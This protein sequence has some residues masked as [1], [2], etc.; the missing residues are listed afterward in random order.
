MHF[1][2]VPFFCW[3][4]CSFFLHICCQCVLQI[5]DEAEN[6]RNLTWTGN[7]LSSRVFFFEV[8]SFHDSKTLS[9]FSF[10]LYS[11]NENTLCWHPVRPSVRSCLIDQHP[12]NRFSDFLQIWNTRF[13][14]K[15]VEVGRVLLKSDQWQSCFTIL[16]QWVYTPRICWLI[17]IKFGVE[18]CTFSGCEFSESRC[19]ESCAVWKSAN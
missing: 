14:Q 16:R 2:F 9:V 1:A 8:L 17:W 18:D 3:F 12:L 5:F 6:L 4:A 10:P 13:L 15:V 19:G 11:T 7:K